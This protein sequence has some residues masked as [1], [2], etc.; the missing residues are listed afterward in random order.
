M[1][2]I[3]NNILYFTVFFS[4]LQGC[5]FLA[6]FQG[7]AVPIWEEKSDRFEPWLFH[8]IE[9]GFV[10]AY[11]MLAFSIIFLVVERLGKSNKGKE[12]NKEILK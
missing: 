1:K 11:P 10:M 6:I 3:K 2:G 7:L 9:F 8:Y 5:I 4:L 12:N